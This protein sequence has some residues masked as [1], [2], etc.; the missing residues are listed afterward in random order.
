MW[1][2][3]F[4]MCWDKLKSPANQPV[5]TLNQS[6]LVN[7][8]NGSPFDTRNLDPASYSLF[9]GPADPVATSTLLED[10]QNPFPNADPKL[11]ELNDVTSLRQY[12]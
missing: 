8:L 6:P 7:H 10:I 11:V 2:A 1:C 3:V 9:T 5:L 4:Q 12:G